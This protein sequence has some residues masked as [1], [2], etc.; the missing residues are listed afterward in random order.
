VKKSSE[1][2][3]DIKKKRK[4]KIGMKNLMMKRKMWFRMK[5]EIKMKSGKF[6]EIDKDV[7][8]LG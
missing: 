4:R 3:K 5:K 8:I 6:L 7:M 2:E 1:I